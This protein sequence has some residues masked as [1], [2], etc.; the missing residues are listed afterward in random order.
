MRQLGSHLRV[1]GPMAG[2]PRRHF[3]GLFSMNSS[4]QFVAPSI[5][6]EKECPIDGD[7]YA[8]EVSYDY[9]TNFEF[10]QCGCGQTHEDFLDDLSREW[11]NYDD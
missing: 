1:G 6:A 3:W 9:E 11:E 10:W 7:Y 5:D 2:S 4:G 8:V